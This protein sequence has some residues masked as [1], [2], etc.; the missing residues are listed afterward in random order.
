[1]NR[2]SLPGIA[3]LAAATLSGCNS[4]PVRDPEYAP[5][6]VPVP[7]QQPATAVTGSLFTPGTRHLVLWEDNRA[8][9]VGDL[10]TIKLIEKMDATKSSSVTADR[11]TS[12]SVTN[13]T[14]FGRTFKLSD[15]PNDTLA[16]SLSASTSNAGSGD[17]A[18]SNTLEGTITVSVIEVQPNGNLTVRGEK[19]V[20]INQ[21]HEYIRIEGIVRPDDIAPDNTVESTRIAN[22]MIDYGGEGP[23]ADASKVG[24]LAR[25]FISAIFPF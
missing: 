3:L 19:L 10:L 13:P 5:P 25:F 7:A 4:A 6:P 16:S 20:G 21:G 2:I 15:N 11:S 24:W 17:A 14:L 8:A 23:V 12:V 1:M 22:V 18:K 9:H